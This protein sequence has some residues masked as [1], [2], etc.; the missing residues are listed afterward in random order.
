ML[1]TGSGIWLHSALIVHQARFLRLCARYILQL[2]ESDSNEKCCARINENLSALPQNWQIVEPN[3]EGGIAVAAYV[4]S[5]DATHLQVRQVRQVG[6]LS[7]TQ[8]IAVPS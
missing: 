5:A 6:L 8:T 2:Q 7:G 4:S 1:D 3:H